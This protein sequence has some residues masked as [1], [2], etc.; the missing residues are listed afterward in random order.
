MMLENGKAN[1]LA[2]Y[3][4][5]LGPIKDN[6]DGTDVSFRKNNMKEDRAP[7]DL[8]RGGGG[9][10]ISP[11]ARPRGGAGREAHEQL[12]EAA[13]KREKT[14]KSIVTETEGKGVSRR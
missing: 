9:P 5:K 1:I 7:K 12:R 4:R 8:G 11:G 13:G 2:E 3:Y 6:G 14:R 10:G